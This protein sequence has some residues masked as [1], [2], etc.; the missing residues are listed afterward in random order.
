[1]KVNAASCTVPTVHIPYLQTVNAAS[2]TVPTVHIPYL[3]T[4]GVSS[5]QGRGYV[6]HTCMWHRDEGMLRHV[7]TR[8]RDIR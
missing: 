4:K 2:C 7:D 8:A 5:K 1:M 6:V 3:Q